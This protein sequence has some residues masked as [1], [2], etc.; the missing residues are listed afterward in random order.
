MLTW[1]DWY[2]RRRIQAPESMEDILRH[3]RAGATGPLMA[4]AEECADLLDEFTADREAFARKVG[5]RKVAED[6]GVRLGLMSPFVSGFARPETRAAVLPTPPLGLLLTKET[7]DLLGDADPP[8]DDWRDLTFGPGPDQ[9][10]RT[11]VYVDVPHGALLVGSGLQV[12]AIFAIPMLVDGEAGGLR[13]DGRV[14]VHGLVTA[15]GSEHESGSVFAVV[16]PDGAVTLLVL[17]PDTVM[18]GIDMGDGAATGSPEWVAVY[19]RVMENSVRF[20][21][22]ALAYHRYGPHDARQPIG[23]T[24][25]ERAA[26]NNFRPKKGESL[27]AVTKLAAPADRM[28]RPPAN[29]AGGW[30]LAARQ[31]VAGHFKLQPHGPG[32]SLRKMI[33]VQ[34]Y[35]RGPEDA[36]VK[37]KA[38]RL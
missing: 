7:A 27:F 23:R 18:G 37:P 29:G 8:G 34:A 14:L 28:G 31:E 3:M 19:H 15:T 32:G 16:L 26:T 17:D 12:R 13:W 20:L 38:V 1:L 11:G 30:N 24:P 36:P 6:M 35:P 25:P 4:F 21:R 2:V 9:D 5:N 22:M 10:R 33:W